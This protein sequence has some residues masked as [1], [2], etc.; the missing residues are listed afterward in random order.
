MLDAKVKPGL[1]TPPRF[2]NAITASPKPA[3][4]V[5]ASWASAI[6]SPAGMLQAASAAVAGSSALTAPITLFA[7]GEIRSL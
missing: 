7:S 1:R 3:G 5:A 4:A 6:S 2:M